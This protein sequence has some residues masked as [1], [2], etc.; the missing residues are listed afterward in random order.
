M[1]WKDAH[2]SSKGR[3]RTNVNSA[4]DPDSALCEDSRCRAE[5]VV[6][7]GNKGLTRSGN[8][9]PEFGLLSAV[10][11]NDIPPCIMASVSM[12]VPHNLPASMGV[13]RWWTGKGDN[14]M[15][16]QVFKINFRHSHSKTLRT[17]A[18]DQM[19]HLPVCFPED[20][21]LLLHAVPPIFMNLAKA[22]SGLLGYRTHSWSWLHGTSTVRW[23]VPEAHSR[24]CYL[25]A[26]C[27]H[28]AKATKKAL[29][30]WLC[31]FDLANLADS[32]SLVLPEASPS[33]VHG[34][35]KIR[36]N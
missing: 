36:R 9:T 2:C 31:L 29:R 17:P 19:C 13:K 4:G 11:G 12:W 10:A 16:V 23:R 1:T 18:S 6:S 21:A 14:G 33:S 35:W 8:F 32:G 15:G 30:G 24:D 28:N 20:A 34:K 22:G 27:P 25:P 26:E 5:G 3:R 7:I